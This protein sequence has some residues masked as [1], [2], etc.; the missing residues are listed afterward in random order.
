MISLRLGT[1][2]DLASIEAIVTD[3]V[4]AMNIEGNYQW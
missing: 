2:D 4:L 1:K 3:I